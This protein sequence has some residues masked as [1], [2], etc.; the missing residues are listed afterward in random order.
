MIAWIRKKLCEKFGHKTETA[1]PDGRIIQHYE[2]RRCG[3]R[4][5]EWIIKWK[6]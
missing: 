6:K 1:T 4:I 2:C 3:V 5:R